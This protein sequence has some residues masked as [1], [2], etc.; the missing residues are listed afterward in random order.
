[1]PLIQVFFS[2]HTRVRT[3]ISTIQEVLDRITAW[4]TN[5]K[6]KLNCNKMK[7]MFRPRNKMVDVLPCV[8][9]NEEI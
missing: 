2:A 4:T 7:A 9:N 5:N 3:T 6:F 1:M 8:K